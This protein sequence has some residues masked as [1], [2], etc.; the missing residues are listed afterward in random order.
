MA[1]LP[2]AR[3]A[4]ASRADAERWFHTAMGALVAVITLGGFARTYYL[5]ALFEQP[6]RAP[7]PSW[8]LAT[9][10]ALFTAWIAFQ[11]S[12]PWLVAAGRVALHK[13][14][15]WAGAGLALA[16]WFMGNL[17]SAR[18]MDVGYRGMG[19]PHAFYAVTFF[20]MQA[21]AVIVA[22]AI[23]WRR[24][25]ATHKRLMLLSNAA[26]LEAAIGRMPWL[27]IDPGSAPFYFYLGADFIIL[28]G[29][30]FDLATRGR[31]HRAWWIGGGLL[32]L[33]QVGRVMI[34]HSEPWLQ[35]ARTVAG[36]VA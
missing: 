21:F 9:H 1:T 29:I 3:P 2:Y 24:D 36:L 17:V 12:Q 16:V 32:A 33:S 4:A 19:D 6:S 11:V 20:S 8:E 15:G 30:A 5:R 27:D 31:V 26:I 28:A 23:W 25:G 34:M 7:D 18:A 13:K 14:L 22:A 10:G 35:F